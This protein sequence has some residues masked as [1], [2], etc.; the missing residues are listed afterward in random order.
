M[1]PDHDDFVL[2]CAVDYADGVPDGGDVVTHFVGDGKGYVWGW[3]G[4]IGGV[5]GSDPV[6][7]VHLFA[8]GTEA[9]KGLD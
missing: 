9:I 2:G 4:R 8:R 7:S 3:P 6:C 5:E 1:V